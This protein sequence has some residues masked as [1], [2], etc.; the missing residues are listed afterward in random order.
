MLVSPK[1]KGVPA[2]FAGF[3]TVGTVF[4]SKFPCEVLLKVLFREKSVRNR[5]GVLVALGLCSNN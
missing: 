5:L 2:A 1:A 3:S 4:A